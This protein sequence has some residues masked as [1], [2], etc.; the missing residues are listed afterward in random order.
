MPSDVKASGSTQPGR[1]NFCRR[2]APTI[3]SPD[4]VRA[5]G[6][7]PGGVVSST[8]RSD[9]SATTRGIHPPPISCL[10]RDAPVA[11][12]TRARPSSPATYAMSP[13]RLSTEPAPIGRTSP[14]LSRTTPF[15]LPASTTSG[16]E[17]DKGA[18]VAAGSRQPA[19][20]EAAS[21]PPDSVRNERRVVM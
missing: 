1:L 3:K 6:G 15:G 4:C 5:A 12:D 2:P 20:T 21:T 9:D 7:S 18:A 16:T 11:A 17:D 10:W 14:P 13:A 19:R 8:H